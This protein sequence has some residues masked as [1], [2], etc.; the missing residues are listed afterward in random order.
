[1]NDFIT[2]ERVSEITGYSLGV[3]SNKRMK[4]EEF[5]F[6]KMGRKIFYKESEVLSAMETSKV[7]ATKKAGTHAS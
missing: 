7:E 1:M 6:Y 5:S 2:P 3:L 4:K